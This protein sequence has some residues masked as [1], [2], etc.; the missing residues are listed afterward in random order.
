MSTLHKTYKGIF[1][2][3]YITKYG[4]YDCIMAQNVFNTFKLPLQYIISWF[5]D[6]K[7]LA[8]KINMYQKSFRLWVLKVANS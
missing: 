6:N 2:Q 5:W 3:L 1:I 7:V 4:L 8:L